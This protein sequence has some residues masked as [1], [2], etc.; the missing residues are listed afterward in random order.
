MPAALPRAGPHKWP[1][2][3]RTIAAHPELTG[4][5]VANHVANCCMAMPRYGDHCEIHCNFAKL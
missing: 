4:R 2:V 5:Q 1:G 3:Y